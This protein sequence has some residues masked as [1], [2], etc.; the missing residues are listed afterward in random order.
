MVKKYSGYNNYDSAEYSIGEGKNTAEKRREKR[1]IAELNKKRL[2]ADKKLSELEK[3]FNKKEADFKEKELA[4]VKELQE[5]DKQIHEK[6]SLR[7]QVNSNKSLDD[8]EKEKQLS[9]IDSDI[10]NLEF[11]KERK[12][13]QLDKIKDRELRDLGNFYSSRKVQIRK[14]ESLEEK[15][16]KKIDKANRIINKNLFT[17]TAATFFRDLSKGN[18]LGAFGAIGQGMT[19]AMQRSNSIL[20]K[21]AG[22]MMHGVGSVVDD[23]SGALISEKHRLSTFLSEHAALKQQETDELL[24][25]LKEKVREFKEKYTTLE[26][27]TDALTEGGFVSNIA[28]LIPLAKLSLRSE[29]I[30]D[31]LDFLERA[32]ENKEFEE[33]IKKKR[34]KQKED[35]YDFRFEREFKDKEFERKRF[36]DNARRIPSKDKTFKP[37]EDSEERMTFAD[38]NQVDAYNR[39]ELKKVLLEFFNHINEVKNGNIKRAERAEK[40]EEER[41]STIKS[42]FKTVVAGATVA[43]AV[44]LAKKFSKTISDVIDDVVARAKSWWDSL[45][46]NNQKDMDKIMKAVSDDESTLSAE[47]GE[48]DTIIPKE[49]LKAEKNEEAKRVEFKEAAKEFKDYQISLP[50]DRQMTQKEWK[51]FGKLRDN[52]NKATNDY[53]QARRELRDVQNMPNVE[54]KSYNAPSFMQNLNNRVSTTSSLLTSLN[55]VSTIANVAGAVKDTYFNTNVSSQ[56]NQNTSTNTINPEINIIEEVERKYKLENAIKKEPLKSSS[57]Y[58]L[59]PAISLS[60]QLSGGGLDYLNN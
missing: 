26:G 2:D 29:D 27:W 14:V 30:F 25:P 1:D 49:V 21:M 8:K 20:L 42:L 13:D 28:A 9:V 16:Q 10:N 22:S 36:L 35:K 45:W 4:L 50:K 39:E 41:K 57:E 31:R 7:N 58:I 47:L 12:Q 54:L 55:P 52:Y 6:D 37:L 43:I 51:K 34:E 44:Y 23:L 5:L 59:P 53:F 15:L 17:Q 24:F 18:V 3:R 56:V 11:R 46:G 48:L 60:S 19:R 40:R 33:E 32:A 38:Y